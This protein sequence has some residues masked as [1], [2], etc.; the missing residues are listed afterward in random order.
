MNSINKFNMTILDCLLHGKFSS[1]GDLGT[2]LVLKESL[3]EATRASLVDSLGCDMPRCSKGSKLLFYGI[4][5]IH[6][7]SALKATRAIVDCMA[8]ADEKLFLRFST[9]SLLS[10][11]V[12]LVNIPYDCF[13]KSLKYYTAYP[14]AFFLKN[15]LPP[16]PDNIS[17]NYP[18]PG[19]CAVRSWLKVRL[20]SKSHYTKNL[21][22]FWSLLQGVKR[23]CEFADDSFIKMTMLKHKSVLSTVDNTCTL[24]H[25][26]TFI[27]DELE[28]YCQNYVKFFKNLN[29]NLDQDYEISNSA[30][31]ERTRSNGGARGEILDISNDVYCEVHRSV[32]SS[33]LSS[34]LHKMIEVSPGIVKELRGVRTPVWNEL[35]S[36]V[37]SERPKAMVAAI[38]EPLKVRLITKGP[39]VD[40]Y[41]SK[42]FQKSLFRYL[43]TFPQ[44]ELTGDPLRPDHLYR[45]IERE[46]Y[47]ENKGMTFSHFVSGDY[48]AATDNLKITFSKLGLLTAMSKF[49]TP[50]A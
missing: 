9:K 2:H 20:F 21:K 33:T 11:F 18:F 46:K 37:S 25:D 44:F 34:V 3:C 5:P 19:N 47:L 50:L 39:A 28:A 8:D 12:S 23:A 4:E 43:R 22:F 45:M 35:N 26:Y 31:W 48:S 17:G 36:L 24:S 13:I 41:L 16:R 14:L 42:S 49:S 29:P 38:L 10:I 40:Y 7:K 1:A 6:V 15:D 32:V 30:C 27:D